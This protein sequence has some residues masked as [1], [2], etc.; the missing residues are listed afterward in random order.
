MRLCAL[1]LGVSF[2]FILKIWIKCYYV[3]E[4]HRYAMLANYFTEYFCTS[5]SLSKRLFS[6]AYTLSSLLTMA[7][8]GVS[9]GFSRWHRKIQ[10]L[11]F[12]VIFRVN[13]RFYLILIPCSLLLASDRWRGD[14][15]LS[16]LCDLLIISSDSVMSA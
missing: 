15:N 1:L 6:S 8:K 10:E 14:L 13:C 9:P 4:W 7:A 12:A 16:D 3:S 2:V 11:I 5:N